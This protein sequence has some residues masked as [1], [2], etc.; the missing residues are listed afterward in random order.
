MVD[1]LAGAIPADLIE[2]HR[3]DGGGH[4]V[5]GEGWIDHDPRIAAGILH[6][7]LGRLHGRTEGP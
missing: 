4:L 5:S 2:V 6:R 1:E 3:Y 7:V